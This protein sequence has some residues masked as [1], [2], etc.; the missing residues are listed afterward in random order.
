MEKLN[1]FIME[2]NYVYLTTNLINGKQYIG[3]HTENEKTRKKKY[4]IG[5]G[6]YF[7]KAVK[8]YGDKNFFKEIIEWFSTKEEAF[9]AQEKYILKFNTLIPNGYN[10]SPKGGFGVPGSYHNNETKIKIS[11]SNMGKCCNLGNK[12]NLGNKHSEETKE[13]IRQAHKGKKQ[14]KE[15][16]EKRFK[17]FYR[18]YKLGSE[19]PLYGTHHSKETKE[20]IS[21]SLK[22]KK[23]SIKH[24]NNISKSAKKIKRRKI[25]KECPYCHKILDHLNFGKYHGIKCKSFILYQ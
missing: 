25:L 12:F 9:S 24:K 2:L 6:N 5:S 11:Q 16:I 18:E 3:D 13:K 15:H 22:G 1:S 4:Y 7:S 10:I 23:Y 19:N 17:N 8:R 20:K 21:L 14:S